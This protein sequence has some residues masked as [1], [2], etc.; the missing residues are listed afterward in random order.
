VPAYQ[1]LMQ[2]VDVFEW[3][4]FPLISALEHRQVSKARSNEQVSTPT[5]T[6]WIGDGDNNADEGKVVLNYATR[7]RCD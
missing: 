6:S 1:D 4:L 5:I 3:V 2:V 7:G